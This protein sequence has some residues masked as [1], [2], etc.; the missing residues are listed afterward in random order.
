M[1][2]GLGYDYTINEYYSTISKVVGFEG[3]FVHDLT[4]PVGMK[5]K[6]VDVEKLEA[7]GWKSKLSLEEGISKTYTYFLENYGNTK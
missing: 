7:F 5:Q 2:V 6:L 3:D 4:K 1:N